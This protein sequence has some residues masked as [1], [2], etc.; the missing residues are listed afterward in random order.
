MTDQMTPI[1]FDQL[2]RWILTEQRHGS[3]FGVRRA[4]KPTAGKQLELFGERLET[5]FGPAA[6]PH[7]QL[8]QNLIAAYYAGSRFFELKTVQIM[9]GEELSA[10]VPKPCIT[11][12]DECYNC[13]WSTELTVPQALD[14]YINAWY[15]LKLLTRAFGWGD[16]DG[17]IFNMSVG[18]DFAGITSEKIDR[19]LEGLKDASNTDAFQ[20][21][22]AW[23]EAHLDSLPGVDAAYL[24]AINPHVCTSITL[25]TLHGCPPQEI[26][27]IASYLIEK[28]KLHTFVK[29]NPTILGYAFARNTLDALGFDYTAFDEHHFEEDLQYGDAV[30]MFRRLIALAD[31]HGVTFGL[32]LSN[33]FPVEVRQKELP[34]GEMYMSGRSLYPLTI[35][36]ARRISREFDGK[37]RLSF[38]GGADAFNIEALFDAGIWPITLATTLLKPGG[39]QRLTQ[40]AERLQSHDYRPFDGV[41]VGK[42][43]HLAEQARRSVRHEKA[44]KPAPPRKLGT[45]VPLMDCFTAPCA[46]GCPIHQDIPEYVELVG[47]GDYA[48]ALRLILEKNPL[49]FITGTICSHRCMDKCTRNF[50]E[51]SVHIRDAK[52]AAACGGFDRIIGT[53][54]PEAKLSDVRVAVVGGGPAG[55]AVS[56]FLGRAGAAVTLFEQREALG[57][58][59]RYVIPA[60]RIEDERIDRDA[61]ILRTMGVDIR[62]GVTA[63]DAAA[64]KAEGYTHIVYAVG[65]WKPGSLRLERGAAMNVLSFLEAYKAGTLRPLGEDVVVIGGGNTAMDAARAAKRVKGVKHVRLVYRRTRRYMPADEE[66]LRLALDD[67]VEF[68][69]LLAPEALENGL[70]RCSVMKLG[71]ADASG[72]RSPIATG[73]TRLLPCSALIAAVGEQVDGALLSKNGIQ[74]TDR[75]RAAVDGLLQT[76]L[77]GVY[78]IGDANRGPATVVEA[79][80]DARTVADAITGERTVSIP[81]GA[82]VTPARCAEKHGILRDY[83]CAEK[84]AGRCLHCPTICECCVQ[85]CPNRANIAIDVPEL[86][87]PQILHVDRMCNECGNCMMFCPYDSRPYKEKLT[88]FSTR[89]AFEENDNP[90]FLPLGGKRLLLRIGCAADSAAEEIDLSQPNALDPALAR[91]LNAVLTDYEY[92]L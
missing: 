35:E 75:G 30:P 87:I 39:Y 85:V 48:G 15:A 43:A 12:P 57:G 7:T 65:A 28:K 83:D 62:T 17:F 81:D 24:D 69:E 13:E 29:C 10:C 45:K 4:F 34:S 90:G 44:I 53:L 18:Y 68:S 91:F 84:E 89:A 72:R 23:A 55:M 40:M 36:M 27:R 2:M 9:D 70:L 51:E 86:P 19:F 14:E 41:S 56:F 76:N 25:S 71:A 31:K 33:T 50:Y 66:E 5:P 79:I 38:S 47:K 3:V 88:L 60:F 49:P 59:V 6:G 20:S 1:P 32:K 37:L 63:P 74:L 52:L 11:A 61:D 67:G 80:A 22:R 8:A 73:E 26:E 78:V 77:D 46:H 58:V 42:V 21:C 92:L 16:P 82:S 64:L 54:R